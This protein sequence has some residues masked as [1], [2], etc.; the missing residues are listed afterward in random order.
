MRT[1]SGSDYRSDIPPFDTPTKNHP[2]MEMD[3]LEAAITSLDVAQPLTTDHLAQLLRGLALTITNKFDRLLA[4]KDDQIRDLQSR[5]SGLE[6][7]CDDLEQYSR[8][9]I[10]RIRG[11]PERRDEDTDEMVKELAA[12]KLEVKVGYSDIVRSHRIGRKNDDKATPRDI[13]VSFT[14]HNTKTAIMR[15]GRKLK[16]T[17]IFIN[18]D[19][20]KIRGAI[21]WEAR[22]LRR[23]GKLIDTWTRDGMIYIKLAENQIKSFTAAR[24]WKLFV[25]KL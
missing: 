6:E 12:Q 11:I 3:A 14:S 2:T 18:E 17:K 9:N 16:G 25:D 22:K 23:E 5:V 21:A 10:V 20:T 4:K 8:R 19:L 24:P 15:N 13:I 1:R 7:K